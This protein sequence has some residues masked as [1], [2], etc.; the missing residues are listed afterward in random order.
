MTLKL[1]SLIKIWEHF[2]MFNKKIKEMILGALLFYG[3]DRTIRL[4][5]SSIDI[6]F[7]KEHAKCQIE[8][9]II[10][11]LAVIILFNTQ[12]V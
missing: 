9:I 3:I 4:M 2:K 6:H 12:G 8:L 10:I 11:F 7:E 5:G 1:A